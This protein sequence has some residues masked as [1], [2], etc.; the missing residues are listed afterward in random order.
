MDGNL[1]GGRRGEKQGEE[2][3]IKETISRQR[4]LPPGRKVLFNSLNLNV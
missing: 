2:V 1:Q 4:E 3:L